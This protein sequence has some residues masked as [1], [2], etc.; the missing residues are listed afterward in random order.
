MLKVDALVLLYIKIC[1]TFVAI[2]QKLKVVCYKQGKLHALLLLAP[3]LRE[4]IVLKYNNNQKVS[5]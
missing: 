1:F 5:Y 3:V 2:Y 4:R